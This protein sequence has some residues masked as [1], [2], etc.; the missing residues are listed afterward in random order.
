MKQARDTLDVI[1]LM[2]R[3]LLASAFLSASAHAHDG[4]PGMT[5]APRTGKLG[6]VSFGNSCQPRVK[7]EFNRGVALLH[8]FWLDEATRSFEKVRS[9]ER[10]VGKECR[11]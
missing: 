9:E 4:M 11:P 2:I 6:T 7:A 10:R 3:A 5:D 8:S 1:R